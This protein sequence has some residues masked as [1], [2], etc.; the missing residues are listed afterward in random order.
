V[1]RIKSR[2][3]SIAFADPHYSRWRHFFDKVCLSWRQNNRQI[4]FLHVY[5][6]ATTFFPVWWAVVKFG[7]GGEA[8]FCCMLNSLIHVLMCA[9]PVN[10]IFVFFFGDPEAK[11]NP[12]FDPFR[13]VYPSEGYSPS[14]SN[15]STMEKGV[16]RVLLYPQLPSPSARVQAPHSA[17]WWQCLVAVICCMLRCLYNLVRSS[18][19]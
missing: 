13:A 10:A 15:I 12:M 9:L 8:W 11:L 2:H 17:I 7:P 5:H 4:S 3:C 19:R 6:H 1:D 16:S 18:V 14:K